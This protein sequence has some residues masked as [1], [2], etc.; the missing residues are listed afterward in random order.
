MINYW[1]VIS[2]IVDFYYA[3]FYN[4]VVMEWKDSAI[5]LHRSK[6]SDKLMV[7]T[8]FSSKH[9]LARGAVGN[10]KK[11]QSITDVGNIVSLSW[12]GR[13]EEHLGKFKIESCE[14]IYPFIY[15]DAVKMS[16][17]I[18]LCDIF[19]NVLAPKDPSKVLYGYL[20]DFLYSIKYNEN[21]WLQRLLFLEL[22]ILSHSGFGLDL[23]KCAA[24]GSEENLYYI[25]PK[26]GKAISKEAGFPYDSKLFKMTET[27]KDIESEAGLADILESLSITQYFL[28]KHLNIPESRKKFIQMV[29]VLQK[30]KDNLESI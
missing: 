18:N 5:I 3:I 11:N 10:N 8:C 21:N 12:R 2:R 26:T 15:S 4:L 19:R 13:L 29:S 22:E 25:S 24:T 16:A 6:Y 1:V 9:G 20:E 14:T 17:M 27:L 30:N 7:L 28:E 23:S